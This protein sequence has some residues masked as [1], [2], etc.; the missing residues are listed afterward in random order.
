MTGFPPIGVTLLFITV[1]LRASWRSAGRSRRRPSSRCR[2]RDRDERVARR[3]KTNQR[4]L[5]RREEE[6]VVRD[7]SSNTASGRPS[8]DASK[9]MAGPSTS[10]GPSGNQE[11]STASGETPA[12][13]RE[14]VENVAPFPEQ[15][16]TT[17]AYSSE[18]V[19]EGND[20]A[21]SCDGTPP[22][23]SESPPSRAASPSFAR[24]DPSGLRRD[25][26]GL[27]SNWISNCCSFLS[28]FSTAA[29]DD[30]SSVDEVDDVPGPVTESTETKRKKRK[31]KENVDCCSETAAH[32]HCEKLRYCSRCEK[33]KMCDV[34]F[35]GKK[36]KFFKTCSRCRDEMTETKR[37]KRKTKENVE[38]C[39]E[40]AAHDNCEK[41]R[42]CSR[43]VMEKKCDVFFDGKNKFFKTC[44][45]CRDEMTE[46]KRNKRKT[47]E[48]VDYCSETAAHDHC[49]K[50]RLCS[51]CVMEKACDVFFDGKKNKFFKTC[52]LCLETIKKW[53]AQR[54]EAAAEAARTN[55]GVRGL[56]FLDSDGIS[57]VAASALNR[58]KDKFAAGSKSYFYAFQWS[59][60]SGWGASAGELHAAEKTESISH[61]L[62]NNGVLQYSN[63]ENGDLRPAKLSD[64]FGTTTTILHRVA[65]SPLI[66]DIRE[67][68][69]KLHELTEG[70]A[71]GFRG[72]LKN[73]GTGTYQKRGTIYGVS[74]LEIPDPEAL[75]L[76]VRDDHRE[77]YEDEVKQY[78]GR[79]RAL[80]FPDVQVDFQLPPTDGN[81]DGG[82]FFVLG[83]ALFEQRRGL[84]VDD[85]R[86]GE[87]TL[88]QQQS[89]GHP[90]ED[91]LR[92]EAAADRIVEWDGAWPSGHVYFSGVTANSI[93]EVAF[94]NALQEMG[95]VVVDKKGPP[96]K[97]EQMK[98]LVVDF[99]NMK[100]DLTRKA[101]H[102]L[103]N[104]IPIISK[105]MF[106]SELMNL[107]YYTDETEE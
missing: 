38:Y 85:S 97:K 76:R 66:D 54:T 65:I 30:A 17:R 100:W 62:R 72:H 4:T 34:F 98:L 90:D 63:P 87:F 51:R 74:I 18:I 42:H 35:D 19:E 47:K 67:I 1:E 22:M 7:A 37:K 93:M 53:E 77:K 20:D 94:H 26:T 105:Q 81:G 43:C 3:G 91:R 79:A 82:T 32:D 31:T 24:D 44:S 68:E 46:T 29:D 9:P 56:T 102:A 80:S 28:C 64:V 95:S 88:S 25:A 57:A 73:G 6:R 10:S 70:D 61:L 60:A 8:D 49:E 75:N 83:G 106:I 89:Q 13:A 5:Q 107:T 55:P 14:K 86:L 16:R 69:R 36:N 59:L 92:R 101:K 33:E 15:R 48:N 96:S 39:S 41:L 27:Q 23:W 45:R 78:G 99:D 52:S 58:L 2:P 12:F 84:P 103:D 71:V 104:H 21:E 11:H 40:T 50:L